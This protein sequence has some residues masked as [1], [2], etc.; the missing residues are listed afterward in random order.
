M[1]YR[2]RSAKNF[3]AEGKVG[4]GCVQRRRIPFSEPKMQFSDV[5][6]QDWLS[7]LSGISGSGAFVD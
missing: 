2:Y 6:Y 7:M 3:I 1:S 4:Y 5:G